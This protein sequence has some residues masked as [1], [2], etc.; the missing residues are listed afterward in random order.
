MLTYNPQSGVA[1]FSCHKC[2]DTQYPCL[3]C[4]QER[5]V[6]DVAFKDGSLGNPFE[7]VGFD[8]NHTNIYRVGYNNGLNAT[9]QKGNM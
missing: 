6:Y 7:V 5:S 1:V 9:C 8:Q 2:K 4:S 3:S